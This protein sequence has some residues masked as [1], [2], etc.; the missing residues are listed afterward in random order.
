MKKV[1]KMLVMLLLLSAAITLGWCAAPDEKPTAGDEEKGYVASRR[2]R[3]RVQVQSAVIDHYAA[4]MTKD[5]RIE[6]PYYV[7]DATA[8]SA[9]QPKTPERKVDQ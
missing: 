5:G 2:P 7:E 9:A 1:K 8:K 3:N 6:M 4:V